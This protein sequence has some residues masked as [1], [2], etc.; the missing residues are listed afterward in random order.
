MI[1]EV[2]ILDVKETLADEYQ[3]WKSLLNH[4]DEP[5]PVVEH[6]EDL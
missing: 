6:Y 5:F 4:F 1:L 2:V 3:E